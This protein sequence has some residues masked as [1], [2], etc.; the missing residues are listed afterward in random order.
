MART[1]LRVT[2]VVLLLSSTGAAETFSRG[3]PA[4]RQRSDVAS[5]WFDQ[6]YQIVKA[7]GTAPPPASRIYGVAAV[8]LY[9]SV[10]PGSGRN[11][12]LVGQ[13]NGLTGVPEPHRHRE[14]YWP[15]VANS[16][17]A[18]TIRDLFPSLTPASQAAID[19]LEASFDDRFRAHLKGRRVRTVGRAGPG[20]RRR[21]P[22][23]GGRRRFRDF[24]NCPYVPAAVAGAWKPTPPGFRG[25]PGAAV[26]GTAPPDGPR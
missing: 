20:G 2:L 3:K 14:Y 8:A 15:A 23:L 16:A 25:E 9:E 12:S 11:R 18:R 22:G 5:M 13:L 21:H 1:A 26:L 6:L 4:D 19:T 17:L 24:N 10:V 7:E